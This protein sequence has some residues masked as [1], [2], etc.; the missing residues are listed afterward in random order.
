VLTDLPENKGGYG[1]LLSWFA[2]S[3]RDEALDERLGAV[4]DVQ[5]FA[6]WFRAPG[7]L[8]GY[9]ARFKAG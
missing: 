8:I 1:A 9:A 5:D 2:L 6:D 7:G 3:G 4:L